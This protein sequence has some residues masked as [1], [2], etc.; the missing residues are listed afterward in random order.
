MFH[1]E[2]RIAQDYETDDFDIKE[3]LNRL[4][5]LERHIG[6]CA[7]LGENGPHWQGSER[8]TRLFVD[9]SKITISQSHKA[10]DFKINH[11]FEIAGSNKGKIDNE[12]KAQEMLEFA[13]EQVR[14]AL[15]LKGGLPMGMHSSP[16]VSDIIQT[17]GEIANAAETI[18]RHVNPEWGRRQSVEVFLPGLKYPGRVVSEHGKK[19][20]FSAPLEKAILAK[21]KPALKFQV[22]GTSREIVPVSITS[23]SRGTPDP[24]QALEAWEVIGFDPGGDSFLKAALKSHK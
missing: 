21:L 14:S 5:D 10:R 15:T 22:N 20:L 17:A 6:G 9:P 2:I 8:V 23:R 12:Q 4:D 1:T 19:K 16:E 11:R 13:I 18:I 7:I 24:M 3:A